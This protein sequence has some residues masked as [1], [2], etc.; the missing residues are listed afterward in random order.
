M[1]QF[2]L[3]QGDITALDVDVV[4]NAANTG[5]LGGGGVDGAIHRAAGPALLEECRKLPVNAYGARCPTGE[6][7]ITGAG[8]M[9]CKYI[10]HTAGPVYGKSG[11]NDA[12]KLASCYRSALMLAGQYKA[13]SIAFPNISCGIYGYPLE[14]AAGIA[15]ST[16]RETCAGLMSLKKVIFCCFDSRNYEIYKAKM[17]AKGS[18]N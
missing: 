10:I 11:G 18:T 16:V 15:L 1:A 2:E 17:P 3:I 5:L 4:V 7:R 13:A 8:N 14:E 9:K 6:A 12:E